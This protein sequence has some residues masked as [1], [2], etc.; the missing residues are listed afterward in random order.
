MKIVLF[1]AL[2]LFFI[3]ENSEAKTIRIERSGGAGEWWNPFDSGY[4]SVIENHTATLSTLK[5]T[6]NGS[7]E[8][9]WLSSPHSTGIVTTRSMEEYVRDQINASVLT[10]SANFNFN[11]NGVNYSRNVSW[12]AVNLREN[13]IT[14][15]ILEMP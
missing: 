9:N 11:M 3:A 4:G 5:C 7:V 15:T 2:A 12:D 1:F 8:C 6:G 13:D 10:G 14:V